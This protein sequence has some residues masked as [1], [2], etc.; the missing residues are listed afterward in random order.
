M[1]RAGFEPAWTSLQARRRSSRRRTGVP[2]KTRRERG[3][4]RLFHR[5]NTL[6]RTERSRRLREGRKTR[7]PELEPAI[8]SVERNCRA[9]LATRA[10]MSGEQRLPS[11]HLWH[12]RVCQVSPARLERASPPLQG[13][14]VAAG[15]RGVV[16][17]RGK[18]QWRGVCRL[19]RS[20][21]VHRGISP[22]DQ[23]GWPSRSIPGARSKYLHYS[24][25]LSRSSRTSVA[26]V[27]RGRVVLS[28]DLQC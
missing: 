9:D 5:P 25:R 1:G 4:T 18:P 10:G 3:R 13:G 19:D 6:G 22:S 28:L 27:S 12:T 2:V 8:C 7:L 17:N 23:P 21:R 14:V 26:M 16:C 11:S 24:T 15:P 20:R